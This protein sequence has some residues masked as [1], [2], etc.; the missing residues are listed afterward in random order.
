M[1][2]CVGMFLFLQT[3][4]ETGFLAYMP[5]G[6]LRSCNKHINNSIFRWHTMP[7]WQYSFCIADFSL[8]FDFFPKQPA[9][10]C[11]TCWITREIILSR[12][13]KQWRLVLTLLV[14]QVCGL[15]KVKFTLFCTFQFFQ[16]SPISRA[17]FQ[18]EITSD[19][20][21]MSSGGSLIPGLYW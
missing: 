10:I 7:W 15:L 1:S 12:G 3:A 9:T 8:S 13:G 21:S 2:V 18:N 11:S 20:L 5:I 4:A 16:N 6:F 17:C 14:K 19:L